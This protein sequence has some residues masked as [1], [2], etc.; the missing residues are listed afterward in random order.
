MK[1]S[2]ARE[3][4]EKTIIQLREEILQKDAKIVEFEKRE[5]GY[6]ADLNR[7]VVKYEV[8]KLLNE[9]T[10][11][12][13]VC[14][15]ILQVICETLNFQRAFFWVYNS[16]VKALYCGKSWNVFLRESKSKSESEFELMSRKISFLPGIGLPGR[17]VTSG[18]PNWI[19][20]VVKDNN[21]L[22]ASVAEKLG[23]HSAFGFPILI[24]YKVF[25][26]MEFFTYDFREPDEKLLD[27][28]VDIG[29]LIAEFNWR[30][31]YSK[32]LTGANRF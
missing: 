21:F 11:F 32:I 17:L 23:I 31:S 18:K 8:T 1:T 5:K 27:L 4:K 3:N 2:Q 13:Q 14:E 9:A 7:L 29:N 15:K 16:D 22:R 6:L 19:V 30:N 20:D 12:D 28:M 24:G 25:G 26:T 10:S